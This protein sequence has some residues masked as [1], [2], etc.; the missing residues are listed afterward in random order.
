MLSIHD[1]PGMHVDS[2][3]V[4]PLDAGVVLH[5]PVW[6]APFA[7]T[8]YQ[9]YCTFATAVIGDTSNYFNLNLNDY[10]SSATAELGS[11]D[12]DS[13]GAVGTPSL[14]ISLYSSTTGT[15]LLEDTYVGLHVQQVGTGMAFP[16]AVLEIGYRG[17]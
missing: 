16:G 1:V 14:A 7:C 17:R 9:I 2:L 12:F 4:G 10:T 6:R 8:V 15:A 3:Q 13:V 11:V 5:V